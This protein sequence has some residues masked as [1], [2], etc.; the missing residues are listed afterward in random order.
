[1]PLYL[2]KE[3]IYCLVSMT[4]IKEPKRVQAKQCPIREVLKYF[5]GAWTVEIYWHLSSGSKRFGEL[6]R[7]LEGVSAKVLTQ[8]LRELEELGVIVRDVKET[9]PPQVEYSLSEMGQRFLPILDSISEVGLDLLRKYK[10][11]ISVST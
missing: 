7:A 1:M 2:H 4:E 5:S 6:Q 11:T 10:K 3:S 9:F 8:R